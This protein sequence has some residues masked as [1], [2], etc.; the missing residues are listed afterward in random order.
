LTGPPDYYIWCH[1]NDWYL[2]L[3]PPGGA[4][5]AD[6]WERLEVTPYGVYDPVGIIYTGQAT[7]T[8]D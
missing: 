8:S 2:A 1:V 3:G 5:P 4:P 7:F 6:C